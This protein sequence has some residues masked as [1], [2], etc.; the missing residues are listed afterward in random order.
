MARKKSRWMRFVQTLQGA[1][2]S[3]KVA[4][5]D[6]QVTE[7]E[8]TFVIDNHLDEPTAQAF[9]KLRTEER[10]EVMS[11][12]SLDRREDPTRELKTRLEAIRAEKW[13]GRAAS[14]GTSAAAGTAGGASGNVMQRLGKFL[15]LN[16]LGIAPPPGLQ[17]T[18]SEENEEADGR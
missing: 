17:D 7:L 12:G 4:C 11:R 9:L 10:A 18:S 16:E 15:A 3:M 6:L 5:R 13:G 1:R 14:S 2:G 8:R